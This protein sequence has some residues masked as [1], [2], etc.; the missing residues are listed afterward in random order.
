M[1]KL[2][3]DVDSS[4]R[5]NAQLSMS[6]LVCCSR[7]IA[8]AVLTASCF[9]DACADVVLAQQ[10]NP[11][12]RASALSGGIIAGVVVAGCVV[13]AGMGFVVSRGLARQSARGK[14]KSAQLSY[15]NEMTEADLAIADSI[16]DKVRLELK[17]GVSLN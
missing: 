3:G 13:L 8:T 14:D 12:V 2:T 4:V 5:I 10:A 15:I 6:L 7:C 17:R 1:P 11:N 16:G 9:A